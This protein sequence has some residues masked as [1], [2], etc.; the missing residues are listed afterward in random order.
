VGQGDDVHVGVA[1]VENAN[2][3]TAVFQSLGVLHPM[4][5]F[6]SM[7]RSEFL[8]MAVQPVHIQTSG[9][10]TE[11]KL[12]RRG[13]LPR[14]LRNLVISDPF[15]GGV[16]HPSSSV[17]GWVAAVHRGADLAKVE[18]HMV[19]DVGGLM[20]APEAMVRRWLH[21]PASVGGAGLLPWV[22]SS[23]WLKVLDKHGGKFTAPPAIFDAFTTAHRGEP[24]KAQ[25]EQ[26]FRRLV[27]AD[28]GLLASRPVQR[29]VRRRRGWAQKYGLTAMEAD[30]AVL[31]VVQSLQT[32]GG[33]PRGKLVFVG[34]EEPDKLWTPHMHTGFLPERRLAY[35]R[36]KADRSIVVSV[37]RLSPGVDVVDRLC[38]LLESKTGK[39]QLVAARALLTLPAF[40]AWVVG[41]LPST[42]ALSFHFGQEE[43]ADALRPFGYG[44]PVHA[45]RT[46]MGDCRRHALRGEIYAHQKIRCLPLAIRLLS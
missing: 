16:L 3:V 27:R 2:K 17:R 46:S 31:E 45:G 1:G 30:H 43:L 41:S 35:P 6:S 23:M 18:E 37:A 33:P 4:K 28:L 34:V 26:L 14:I 19:S 38:P 15:A 8:R 36:W 44:I 13:F 29:L 21:T 20:G 24:G 12:V 32:S 22:G 25:T 9:R 42:S 11:T 5:T 40:R 10:G 39:A 7:T